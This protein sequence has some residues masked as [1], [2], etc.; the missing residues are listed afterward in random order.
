MEYLNI[1][2]IFYKIVDLDDYVNPTKP[3]AI[4]F[5]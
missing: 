5:Y 3:V 4:I 1:M 2:I